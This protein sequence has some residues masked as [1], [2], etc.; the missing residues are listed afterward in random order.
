MQG[1]LPGGGR[2]G[3]RWHR[4]M[5]GTNLVTWAQRGGWQPG[6]WAAASSAQ[7]SSEGQN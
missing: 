1:S 4:V 7:S 3:V 6:A 2:A 5:E